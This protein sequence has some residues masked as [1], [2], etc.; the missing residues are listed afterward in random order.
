MMKCKH[1]LQ[2]KG[3]R[4][5]PALSGMICT[6]CCGKYRKKEIDCPETCVFIVG[7]TEYNSK[8]QMDDFGQQYSV[9]GRNL[10][11]KHSENAA[12]LLYKLDASSLVYYVKSEKR[13]K[14]IDMIEGW[15]YLLNRSHSDLIVPNEK[16]PHFADFLMN[17]SN[18]AVQALIKEKE[19]MKEPLQEYIKFIE[20]YIH[21]YGETDKYSSI[22]RKY[23]ESIAES[24]EIEAIMSEYTV[25][26]AD[27]ESKGENSKIVSI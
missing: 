20:D 2:K 4:N 15:E 10:I 27:P 9:F 24:S 26:P 7:N 19:E 6:L 25:Y 16:I 23:L 14:D 11:K 22:H 18:Q 12:E 13:P 21:G 3:K 8:K 1:C 5:C 17:R